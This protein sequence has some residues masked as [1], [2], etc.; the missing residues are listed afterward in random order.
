MMIEIS[1][2]NMQGHMPSLREFTHKVVAKEGMALVTLWSIFPRKSIGH[3]FY[4]SHF[5][6]ITIEDCKHRPW[7]EK[8]H[9]TCNQI[10]NSLKI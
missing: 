9:T 1:N 7:K 6:Q 3:S 2:I 4:A 8:E 5:H 10:E